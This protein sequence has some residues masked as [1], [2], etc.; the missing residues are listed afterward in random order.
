M[1]D[2]DLILKQNRTWGKVQENEPGQILFENGY[3][4]AF[5]GVILGA[6]E[7]VL[8]PGYYNLSASGELV[9]ANQNHALKEKIDDYTKYFGN[10]SFGYREIWDSKNRGIM[11]SVIYAALEININLNYIKDIYNFI[12]SNFKVFGRDDS[13]PVLFESHTRK[14]LTFSIVYGKF[15]KDCYQIKKGRK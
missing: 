11:L 4:V 12:G 7:T 3:A 9:P 1:K 8:Q 10:P 13:S 5:N 6:I 14:L 2:L 15:P